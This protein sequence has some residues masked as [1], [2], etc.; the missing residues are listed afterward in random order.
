V[1]DRAAADAA[2]PVAAALLAA[3][4]AQAP[5][6]VVRAAADRVAAA[7][8][9]VGTAAADQAAVDQA[10]GATVAGTA[11]DRAE[12]VVAD[13]AEAVAI[14]ADSSRVALAARREPTAIPSEHDGVLAAV[15]G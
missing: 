15:H 3:W 9:A 10:A 13:R 12:A 7:D 4:P 2:D 6:E 11:E 14:D 1:A 5:A 8:R